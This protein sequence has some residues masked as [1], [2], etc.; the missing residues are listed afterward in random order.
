MEP[1][2]HPGRDAQS[3]QQQS[4]IDTA[5]GNQADSGLWNPKG[6]QNWQSRSGDGVGR[7]AVLAGTEA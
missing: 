2:G 1:G 3:P 7:K 6:S 5:E 4:G